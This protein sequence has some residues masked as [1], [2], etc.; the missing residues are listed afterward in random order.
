MDAASEALYLAVGFSDCQEF[1]AS[2]AR[3]ITLDYEHQLL[4]RMG[5]SHCASSL[6][7]EGVVDHQLARVPERSEPCIRSGSTPW[8]CGSATMKR[9]G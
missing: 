5:E 7:A 4:K 8:S 9:Y 3:L 1:V 6:I 2:L